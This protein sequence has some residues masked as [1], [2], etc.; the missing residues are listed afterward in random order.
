MNTDTLLFDAG[1][2]RFKW[3]L[4]RGGRLGRQQALPLAEF[5]RFARWLRAA[6]PF[7]RAVGV[8]VAGARCERQLRAA[9]HAAGRPAPE[10]IRSSAAAAGVRNG[11]ARP[12]QLGADRWAGLVGAWHRA[13]CRRTVC[14]A[15]I[16]TAITL[17]VVDQRGRHRG[18]LIAP[19]PALMLA[20][21][22]ERTADIAPR[23]A[24]RTSR[25]SRQRHGDIVPPLA[26]ATRAAIEEGCLAAAAAF[27]DRTVE[28]LARRLG[29]RPLLLITG[30]G[31]PAVAARLR[32]S[33]ESCEDLVLRGVAVLGGVPIRHR[34]C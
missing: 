18:G 11:Y 4:V 15:S 34:P 30:G 2:S 12:G 3:A 33:H 26:G 10:F 27:I 28:Q 20:A 8:N 19:G 31:S 29:V 7:A 25:A 1:N 22:L 17:D 5:T 6:P 21:L 9:L 23:A 16:G 24:A 13:G 14:A 32:R